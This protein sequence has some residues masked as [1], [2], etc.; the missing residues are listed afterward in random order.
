MSG[1]EIL[2]ITFSFV[3]GL[4]VAQ[5]L[6]S[7]G[8]VIRERETVQL[9]WVPFS[10]AALI[11]FFQVQFWFGLAVI[12]SLLERW[13]WPIYGMVFL[14]AVLIFLAGA[15]VLPPPTQIGERSLM[16]DFRSRGRTSLL[17]L[18]AYL[19]AWIGLGIMFWRP[20]FWHLVLVNGV[21]AAVCVLAYAQQ[22]GR[23]W[24]HVVLLA[25]TAY[26]AVTV[27]T[28]PSLQMPMQG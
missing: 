4:G 1:F 25:L 19:I 5:V 18:G 2:T 14:A 28:T 10:V 8:Y 21:Y 3:V 13:A 22:G 7:V 15:T 27:W 12:N 24:T 11:L 16:Q 6:R 26:G 9:H 20:E 23:I 17:F